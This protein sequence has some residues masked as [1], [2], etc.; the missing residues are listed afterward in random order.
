MGGG[1]SLPGADPFLGRGLCEPPV[2]L[3]QRP[4][5]PTFRFRWRAARGGA[6]T[7]TRLD[8]TA[9][10]PQGQ[11]IR[12]GR[13]SESCLGLVAPAEAET[14]WSHGNGIEAADAWRKREK[15]DTSWEQGKEDIPQE[16]KKGDIP[17]ERERGRVSQRRENLKRGAIDLHKKYETNNSYIMR[18]ILQEQ[19]Y[20]NIHNTMGS[21]QAGTRLDTLILAIPRIF[22]ASAT[23]SR[24]PTQFISAITASPR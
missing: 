1:S 6:P 9:P 22:S 8:R 4:A 17:R 3:G 18:K 23:I 14:A 2:D 11:R 10:W 20:I 15:A 7:K 16:W 19:V 21:K 24:E 13:G 12:Q 5:F